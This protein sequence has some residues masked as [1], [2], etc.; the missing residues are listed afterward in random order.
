MSVSNGYT[1]L[2]TMS[3]QGRSR[4]VWLLATVMISLGLLYYTYCTPN[5][6]DKAFIAPAPEAQTDSK[7]QPS[8]APLI[9]TEFNAS[10]TAPAPMLSASPFPADSI[11]KEE[12]AEEE[13]DLMALIKAMYRPDLH[14]ID[15]A[16]FTDEDGIVHHLGG[17]PRFRKKLGKKVLILDVDSRPLTGDGQIMNEKLP[18]KGMRPLSAGMLSHWMF[19]TAGAMGTW[20][21]TGAALTVDS[22][23]SRLR[24]QIHPRTGLRRPMGDLGQSTHD[25]GIPQNAR[26]CR[27]HGLGRHV[28]LPAPPARMAPELLEH[29]RGDARHDVG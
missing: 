23:H 3:P 10:Q 26:L 11:E 17:E 25:E 18:W 6:Y 4:R 19:G 15:A 12:G 1:S 22:Q 21:H 5:V 29:D 9:P 28:P 13:A 16:N 27:L 20:A 14:P 7:W 24:L 8:P 2:A